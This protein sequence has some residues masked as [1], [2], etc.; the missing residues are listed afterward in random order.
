MSALRI[1]SEPILVWSGYGQTDR[2]H[3]GE[4]PWT[5]MFADDILICSISREQV[6]KHI[7]VGV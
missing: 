4:S 7:E 1:G 3:Q 5:I 2:Q 6:E